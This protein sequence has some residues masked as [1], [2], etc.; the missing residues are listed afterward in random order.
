[1]LSCAVVL[2][3]GLGA[4]ALGAGSPGY[5][6]CLARTQAMSE[7]EGKVG[8][9]GGGDSGKVRSR[10]WW[11]YDSDGGNCEGGRQGGG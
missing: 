5:W 7:K 2:V 3:V 6:G 9:G 10:R 11:R 8:G 4:S 1:M